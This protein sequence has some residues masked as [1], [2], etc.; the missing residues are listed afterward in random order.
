[1]KCFFSHLYIQYIQYPDAATTNDEGTPSPLTVAR[2]TETG[3]YTLQTCNRA[4]YQN[5]L[6]LTYSAVTQTFST[7]TVSLPQVFYIILSGSLTYN[8][9]DIL[10]DFT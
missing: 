3:Q 5:K 10:I 8:D 2:D 7:V 4:N 1:M 6:V 9:P